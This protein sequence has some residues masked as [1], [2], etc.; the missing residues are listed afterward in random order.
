MLVNY[1]TTFGIF[2]VFFVTLFASIYF[3]SFHYFGVKQP[4]NIAPLFCFPH[5]WRKARL[6]EGERSQTSNIKCYVEIQCRVL[7]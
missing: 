3:F 1:L 5:Y 2:A 4:Q 6:Y 7:R